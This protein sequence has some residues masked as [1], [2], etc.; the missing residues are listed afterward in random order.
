MSNYFK[1]RTKLVQFVEDKLQS[2]GSNSVLT[3]T[4]IR[5]TSGDYCVLT[6]TEELS[7]DIGKTK[8]QAFLNPPT[9]I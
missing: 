9:S 1:T 5:D 3:M 4:I 2:L 6:A 7:V 8:E